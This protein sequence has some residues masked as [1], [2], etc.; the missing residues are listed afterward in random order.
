MM[1]DMAG[2]A[3]R[4][5]FWVLRWLQHGMTLKPGSRTVGS[6][7]RTCWCCRSAW[8]WTSGTRPA[9]W[10]MD[11][12]AKTLSSPGTSG[13]RAGARRLGSR[14]VTTSWRHRRGRCEL[15]RRMPRRALAGVPRAR[16]QPPPCRLEAAGGC[17]F[18]QW[19]LVAQGSAAAAW[20]WWRA[21]FWAVLGVEAAGLWRQMSG[22]RYGARDPQGLVA[23]TRSA[24]V[25]AV[26]SGQVLVGTCWSRGDAAGR[27]GLSVRVGAKDLEA[28]WR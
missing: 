3:C 15:V 5:G 16:G 13:M 4:R 2:A 12:G 10:V 23:A 18:V 11:V 14:G 20:S 19:R 27:Y 26:K 7:C 24:G 28:R 6:C 9:A 21:R 25:E 8:G 1:E 17:S 22:G